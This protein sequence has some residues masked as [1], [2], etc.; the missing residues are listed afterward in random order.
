M[1]NNVKRRDIKTMSL[2]VASNK[3][4]PSRQDM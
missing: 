1:R 4:K 3:S 2:K